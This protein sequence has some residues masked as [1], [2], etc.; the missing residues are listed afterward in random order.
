VVHGVRGVVRGPK[1][2]SGGSTRVSRGFW[3]W[4]PVQNRARAVSRGRE[5]GSTSNGGR[6]NHDGAALE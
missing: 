6:A 4:H 3:L 5:K 2:T 1:G